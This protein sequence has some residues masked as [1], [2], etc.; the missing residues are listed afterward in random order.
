VDLQVAVHA[1]LQRHGGGPARAVADVGDVHPVGGADQETH[2][3]EVRPTSPV[4]VDLECRYH[5]HLEAQ[6]DQQRGEQPAPLVA[7]PASLASDDLVEEIRNAKRY[8]RAGVDVVVLEGDGPGLGGVQLAERGTTRYGGA[9][10][11]D[12][13][14]HRVNIYADIHEV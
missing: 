11:S 1:R 6:L 13:N 2:V 5:D 8:R 12:P 3:V 10:R 4:V 14:Q 7:E 9:S